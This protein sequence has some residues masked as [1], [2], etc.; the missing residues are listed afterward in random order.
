VPA[1]LLVIHPHAKPAAVINRFVDRKLT[2]TAKCSGS[3]FGARDELERFRKY[4][5]SFVQYDDPPKE[6]S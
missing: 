4:P 1:I 5:N 6:A 2:N 3:L